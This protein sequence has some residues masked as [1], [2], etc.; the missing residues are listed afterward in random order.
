ME[1]LWWR[2]SYDPR[3]LKSFVRLSRLL[4]VPSGQ[5]KEDIVKA[6][7]ANRKGLG[8]ELLSI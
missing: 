7:L 1:R 4:G 6:W 8:D 3:R 5:S 2:C